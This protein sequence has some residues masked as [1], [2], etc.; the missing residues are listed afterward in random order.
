MLYIF[1]PCL[2]HSYCVPE[3]KSS[4]NER[5][6]LVDFILI[7]HHTCR[8][9]LHHILFGVAIWFWLFSY[10]CV[11]VFPCNM[12]IRSSLIDRWIIIIIIIVYAFVC[13]FSKLEHK[14]D[15]CYSLLHCLLLFLLLLQMF[16]TTNTARLVTP[17][18][19][20]QQQRNR[21][22]TPA[23]HLEHHQNQHHAIFLTLATQEAP[24]AAQ[25]KKVLN[26]NSTA[27]V[28]HHQ[29]NRI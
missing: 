1:Q 10:D 22:S 18:A 8:L 28:S 19:Q 13:Y 25:D 12:V 2:P 14:A 26:S 23:T 16:N 6:E 27:C 3:V 15:Y 7:K 21:S 24:N 5:T 9:L 4:V 29:D 17:P 20:Q 11:R